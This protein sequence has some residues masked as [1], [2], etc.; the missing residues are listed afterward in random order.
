M[1]DFLHPGVY[2]EEL[3]TR[4][5]PIEGVATSTA[6]FAGAG[7][8]RRA[9]VFATSYREF[10][11]AAAGIVTGVL[12]LAVR[13]FF[14]NGGRR[15]VVAVGC[16]AHP[17]A[18][19]LQL[20]E[21][22]AFSLICCPDAAAYD[23]A[24]NDLAAF[25]ER[26]ADAV[27]LLDLEAPL[28]PDPLPG[29]HSS[30]VVRYA[31]SI[32]VLDDGV[33][34]AIPPSGHV[35]GAYARNDS[36]RGVHTAPDGIRLT[37]VAGV[38]HAI[39]ADG[40]AALH[41][42]GVNVVRD[43]DGGMVLTGARTGSRDDAV[44]YVPV[45]RLLIYL[46]QSIR[47]GLQWAVVEPNEPALWIGVTQAVRDFLAAAWRRGELLGSRPEEAFFARCDRTTMTQDDIDAGRFV[48]LVGV[49]PLRPAE[50]IILRIT[51]QTTR[52]PDDERRAPA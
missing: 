42:R 39:D 34:V 43:T 36:E 31:P 21:D 9:P 5:R 48:A 35:A 13:G 49:A 14:E 23:G 8:E 4:G 16:G 3:P 40:A 32:V 17:I 38:A 26:R 33:R 20:L 51:G 30:F 45:R 29:G 24:A 27:A 2:V 47:R 12:P 11:D 6:A 22:D 19:A 50:F 7:V 10:A 41:A 1:A 18:E 28:G 44:R 52:R 15:A 46:E 37:G 25:A